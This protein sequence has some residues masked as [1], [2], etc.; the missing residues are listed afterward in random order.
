MVALNLSSPLPGTMLED[1]RIELDIP[2]G[3]TAPVKEEDEDGGISL[4]NVS[5]TFDALEA[6]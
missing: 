5:D 6:S 2:G 4:Q 1:G 3:W